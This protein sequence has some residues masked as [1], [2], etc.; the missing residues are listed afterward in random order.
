MKKLLTATAMTAV[1][2][3]TAFT[4]EAITEF[5]IGILGGENAQDRMTSNE[6][7]R[8]ST[9]DRL[10]VRDKAIMELFYSSGLRLAELLGLAYVEVQGDRVRFYGHPMMRSDVYREGYVAGEDE[11]FVMLDMMVG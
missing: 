5:N 4:Q 8:A 9:D 7:V 6:C 10:G 1:F 11:R 3:S 2:A